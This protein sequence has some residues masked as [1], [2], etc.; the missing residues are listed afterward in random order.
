M[1]KRLGSVLGQSDSQDPLLQSGVPKQTSQQN[2]DAGLP[3]QVNAAIVT[4]S[5]HV[6]SSSAT[7]GEK[8]SEQQCNDGHETTHEDTR[9]SKYQRVRC[10]RN[11]RGGVLW[12]TKQSYPGHKCSTW[13]Y[14]QTGQYLESC[15]YSSTAVANKTYMQLSS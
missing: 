1:L 12:R 7:P 13:L 2:A 14:F 10:T 3:A 9:Q 4:P 11:D 5:A 6:S 15:G 8:G